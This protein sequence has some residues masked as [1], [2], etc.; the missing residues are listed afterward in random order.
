MD[1]LNQIAAKRMKESVPPFSVGDTVRV[2]VRVVEG[3]RERVQAFQGTIIQRRGSGLG[4]TF[5]VRKVTQGVGVERIFPL[6]SPNVS[7][8]RVL[9]RGKVR[10]AKLFYLRQLMGKA[11]RIEEKTEKAEE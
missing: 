9:R 1:I 11:A 8:I 4:E 7:A 2:D 10:R 5:T 3:G 6:H